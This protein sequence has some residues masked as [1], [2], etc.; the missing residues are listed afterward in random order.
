MNHIAQD[1]ARAAIIGYGMAGATIHSRLLKEAGWQVTVILVNNEE[2]R[3]QARRDWPEVQLVTTVEELI[4]QRDQYDAVVVASPTGLHHEHASSLL[5]AKL[6]TVV[7]KPLGITAPQCQRLV[8]LARK[9]QTPLTVFQNRRWDTEQLTLQRVLDEGLVGKVH[10][11]ERRW[12]RWRPSPLTRWKEQDLEGGGLLLDLGAHLVDSAVQLFGPVIRVFA[13]TR[14]MSTPVIDDFFISLE[15][16]GTGG[17]PVFSRLQAGSLVGAPGPRT[18]VLGNGGS[19]VVTTYEAEPSPFSQLDE[20]D[21]GQDEHHGWLSHGAEVTAVTPA[22]G[23][24]ADFYRATQLWLAGNGAIPVDPQDC[25]YTAQ[26]LDGARVSSAEN[27]V[28]E[29]S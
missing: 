15:H 29:L 19:Y 5:E 20:N 23:G 17:I 12:E 8:D 26:I 7:D 16:V 13:Q 25:V 24:H 6:P 4:A 9:T 21:G 22:P 3:S 2:R 10:T 18:R 11:F 27:R 28:V 1:I 14:A